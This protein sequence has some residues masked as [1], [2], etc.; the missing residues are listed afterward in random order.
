M[1]IVTLYKSF[2]YLIFKIAISV[3]Y[4]N[5]FLFRNLHADS[6]I[7]SYDKASSIES[8]IMQQEN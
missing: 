1:Y 7:L 4:L 5:E 2:V 6:F 8:S 3:N